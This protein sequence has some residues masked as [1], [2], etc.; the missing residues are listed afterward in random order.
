VTASPRHALG[1]EAPDPAEFVAEVSPAPPQ[2]PALPG[3]FGTWPV[4]AASADGGHLVAGRT[5]TVAGQGLAVTLGLPSGLSDPAALG[6]VTEWLGEVEVRRADDSPALAPAAVTAVGAFPF[7]PAAPAALVVPARSLVLTADGLAWTVDVRQRRSGRADRPP[8]ASSDATP[9]AEAA[10][11]GGSPRLVQ[12]PAGERY[13]WSVAAAVD[14][15]VA[16]RLRKVVL[17]RMVDL[18]LPEPVPPSIILERLWGGD[19]VFSPFSVPTREGRLVGAS[20]ELLVCRRAHD[21]ASHAFAGTTALTDHDDGSSGAAR[22]LGS[23][24]ER[25]E[26]RLVVEAIA[27]VLEPRCTS[28][29]VPA[30]PSVVR[31]R[32]D[33]RLGT[34]IRGTLRGGDTALT[35]LSLL[36]PT[37][38]VGGVPRAAALARIEALEPVPRGYWAGAVGWTDAT[39]DGDWVLSIRSALLDGPSARVRAGAGVVAGSD[40]A[41]ELAETTVKL[42]P[43]L[44]ALWPGASKLL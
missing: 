2:G 15:I 41:A 39:G 4:L 3:R 26:H 42:S 30:A 5:R 22:L 31:L 27:S 29:A 35:L 10:G 20:P 34:M 40:P 14:A 13:A 25:E 12:V 37:P 21:V 16:G 9:A 24:K 38:A 32:S 6:A 33:A 19:P 28:L 43:V 17:S 1:V 11:G 18:L 44:D 23:D 8:A 7:S 36:H